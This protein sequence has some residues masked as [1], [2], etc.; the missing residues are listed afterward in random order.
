MIEAYGF[1]CKAV[2]ILNL[3]VNTLNFQRYHNDYLKIH[4][5][6]EHNMTHIMSQ[7]VKSFSIELFIAGLSKLSQ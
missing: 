3:V 2:Q 4:V 5:K 6:A 7:P 1:Q